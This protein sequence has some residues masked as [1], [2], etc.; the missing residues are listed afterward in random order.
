MHQ[1]FYPKKI[2]Y[3]GQK[4]Y[5]EKVHAVIYEHIFLTGFP[6]TY[7]IRYATTILLQLEYRQAFYSFGNV[8]Y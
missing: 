5:N 8:R 4:I 2:D 1:Y 6:L 7:I 3:T